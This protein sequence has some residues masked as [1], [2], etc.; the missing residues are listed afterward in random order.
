MQKQ[1][2]FSQIELRI[3]WL[4]K[5]GI[6]PGPLRFLFY[7]F[8]PLQLLGLFLFFFVEQSYCDMFNGWL[9][10]ELYSMGIINLPTYTA[11]FFL[12]NLL[13]LFYLLIQ[14][15]KG[16]VNYPLIFLA[17]CT[18][19]IFYAL[20][21]LSGSVFHLQMN[22]FLYYGIALSALL[23]NLSIWIYVSKLRSKI[24][25]CSYSGAGAGTA[26]LLSPLEQQAQAMEQQGKSATVLRFYLYGWLPIRAA[27]LLFMLLQ[28]WNSA[29]LLSY[30]NYDSYT[31]LDN[32]PAIPLVPL[33][34]SVP[35]N[36]W[37]DYLL[38]GFKFM[39]D[40]FEIVH[41]NSFLN[42]I[43]FYCV[44]TIL[45]L[46]LLLGFQAKS[47]QKMKK[48]FFP[49]FFGSLLLDIPMFCRFFMANYFS[50]WNFLSSFRYKFYLL[51]GI[52]LYALFSVY[53][54]RR[55]DY[56]GKTQ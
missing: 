24:R 30:L 10:E 2:F 25:K 32:S 43:L 14:Y 1:G 26:S 42:I 52:T 41:L 22:A 27:F 37:T 18:N 15:Q 20:P 19:T 33:G 46:L 53:F 28:E 3:G 13:M 54:L 49:L 34:Q 9:E 48:S 11:A 35:F 40:S 6:A 39:R 23:V 5:Q 51:L 38:N 8:L 21:I 56:F 7:G 36:F 44:P 55:K 12:L 31:F 29:L 16:K 45:L 50:Q 47:L 17:L 4:S